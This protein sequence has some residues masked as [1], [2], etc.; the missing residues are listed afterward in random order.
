MIITNRNQYKPFAGTTQRWC[1]TDRE[2][3]WKKNQL[4]PI[5]RESLARLGWT[6]DSVS[7]RFNSQAFRSDEFDGN[8]V[9]FFGCSFTMGIG[10]TWENTW[11][12]QV[13]KAL[14]TKC[15]NL[16]I[17]GGSHD[18]C[19]RNAQ[20]WIPQLKPSRVFVLSPPIN[21]IELLSDVYPLSDGIKHYVP[22]YAGDC[23]YY[24]EWLMDDLNSELNKMKNLY[25][26]A[27]I[28]EKHNI[29]MH[30][31]EVPPNPDGKDLGRDLLHQGRLWHNK[32]AEI[33]LDQV[34]KEL[35]FSPNLLG[36]N[37]SEKRE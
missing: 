11:A 6:E 21:R 17:G 16:G 26:I 13:A 2:P 18:T 33:A 28:C 32:V 15:W 7:Y 30:H 8:G 10:M 34:K 14:D 9:M 1:G 27:F 25:G 3:V 31:M 19:F 20:E 4:I 24:T 12:Y 22:G 5:H 29:P 37:S 23:R 35:T 36:C